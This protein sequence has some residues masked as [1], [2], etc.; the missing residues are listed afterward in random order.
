MMNI[1]TFLKGLQ[2]NNNR[3]WFETNRKKYLE[4]KEEFHQYVTELI[5]EVAKFEPG[6]EGLKAG[7]C[8]FRIN[9]DIRF[10]NDKRP[11]KENFG[12]YISPGGKKSLKGGYYLHL[13]P[14]NES[15]VAGGIYMPTPEMLKMI[16]QEIDYNPDP[17]ISIIKNKSFK[18]SFGE[19]TGEKLK[20][21]PQGYQEDHR[22]A[23]LLK[24]KSYIV[25]HSFNDKD[26]TTANFQKE[27]LKYF[28]GI[29]PLNDYLNS[30]VEE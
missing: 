26:V 30:A 16:R 29:K 4:V 19:I 17:L 22:Y 10:S 21:I 2:K 15:M 13:Q 7:D 25:V 14:G 6:V 28:R 11:Y 3:D 1:L 12:A 8:I 27:A 20:R 18:Q 23:D 5:L 24:L 9:R